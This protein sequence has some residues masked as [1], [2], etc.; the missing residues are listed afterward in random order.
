VSYT[1]DGGYYDQANFFWQPGDTVTVTTHRCYGG[2]VITSHHVTYTTTIPNSLDPRL[3]L[4]SKL[5]KLG[6]VLE[7]SIGGDYAAGALNNVGFILI[8][9]HVNSLG[10]HNFVNEPRAGG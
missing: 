4:S 1:G 6:A 2:G 8:V 7:V 10:H 9:G 3:S 5:F